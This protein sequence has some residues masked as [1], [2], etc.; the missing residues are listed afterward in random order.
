[1]TA[2]RTCLASALGLLAAL[3]LASAAALAADAAK[4]GGK[5][6][7]PRLAVCTCVEVIPPIDCEAQL[8]PGLKQ[9]DG[10]A[11]AIIGQ[12]FEH[13]RKQ[14]EAK[15]SPAECDAADLAPVAAECQGYAAE[16]RK[17]VAA[18][19][20]A[21][22]RAQCK[23][24]NKDWLEECENKVRPEAC[25]TC[26]AMEDELRAAAEEIIQ[27]EQW[28]ADMRASV[29]LKSGDSA[30]LARRIDRNV[31]LQGVLQNKRDNLAMF[32]E[33]RYCK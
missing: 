29:V 8:A 24:A 22:A 28:I 19:E 5:A 21:K 20:I 3:V 30:E 23:A 4:A 7:P 25:A 17:K 9:V 6:A 31:H 10:Q 2:L 14:C 12:C 27:N 16:W 11:K 15:M 33:T 1:M 13:W 26:K 18:P 32:K